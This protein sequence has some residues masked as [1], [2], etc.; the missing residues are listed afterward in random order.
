MDDILKQIFETADDPMVL[1][2][3]DKIA[4]VNPA[5]CKGSGFKD[6]ACSY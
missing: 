6:M 2:L 1:V 3:E 4:K 5:F